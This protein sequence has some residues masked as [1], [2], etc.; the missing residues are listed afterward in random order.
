MLSVEPLKSA[1]GAANYYSNAFNYYSGDASAMKWLGQ[2]SER[3]QLIGVVEKEQMLSLLE[4]R[5]PDGRRLQNLEGE[6]RPGFD[7]TFS[8]PKSVSILV[9]LGVAPELIEFHDEAVEFTIRQI[10]KEFAETR[11]SRQGEISFEKTNNLIVAA[12]RQPSSRANEP[13]LHTHCV[14]MN[15]TFHEGDVRSLASDP[16]R[17]HGVIEQIQ[18]NAHYCG[19]IYRQYLANKIKTAGFHLRITGEGLFEIDGVPEKILQAY[20]TRR[21]EILEYMDEKK[22]SGAKSASIATKITRNI[23]EEHD[24]DV[25]TNAWKE[26]A[27]EMGFDAALFMQHRNKSESMSWCSSIKEKLLAWVGQCKKDATPSEKD[28]A[29]ACVQVAIE[30]LSQ[31][32]SIFSERKLTQEAMKHS[33]IYPSAVSRQSIVECIQL[34]KKHQTLYEE[35]CHQRNET[36]LTTPWLLTLEADTIARIEYNKGLVPAISTL[37][38]V[39]DFQKMRSAVLPYPMTNSQQQA[40]RVLLTSKDRYLAIQGYAGVAK[41]SMLSEARLLI[42]AQGYTLRGITVAS[43]AAHE[44]QDKAGIKADVFPI[45]HQELKEAKTASLPKT[46]FII[47]EASMLSS[48]QGHELIKQIERVGARLVLVGDKAQ[49]PS[50]NAGR[51]FGLIQEYGIET[52]VMDE[53]VRQKNEILKHAVMAT[54]RGDVKDALDHL[55]VQ[56]LSTHE[57]RIIWIANRWLSLSVSEREGTLLFA[58]THANREEITTLIRQGLKQEGSLQGQSF[59]HTVLKAKAMESIQ[60]RFVAYYQE[61]DQVR[62]NQTFKQGQLLAGKYYTVGKI[63]KKHCQDNTLPLIDEKG[64]ITKLHLNHLPHYKTHTAPF[65]RMIEVY[66]PK[67]LELL[68]GDKVMWTRNFRAYELRNGQCATLHEIKKDSLVFISNDGSKLILE[69]SHPALKHLDYSYVLT[70]YKVQGKDAPFG[71]GLMESYHRF[72][73]TLNNFYVQISRAIHG[74]TLVT[75][76]KEEL[77]RAILRNSNEKPASLDM[78]RSEQLMYHE[79]RFSG[80][81]QLSIQPVIDR[82]QFIER[83]VSTETIHPKNSTNNPFIKKM[84][85]D[86]SKSL[87]KEKEL[88]R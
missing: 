79:R 38:T 13:A 77:M 24:I 40:M 21:T 57:E 54:T 53:V 1:Q 8:A 76:N 72:G 5:L 74:M 60:L 10:E 80:K 64:H 48:H 56:L 35:R 14:T 18:N 67:S 27:T 41:T 2:G 4:G 44:L 63:S 75:D 26:R 46:L 65:E 29:Y 23:K 83:Q 9:G 7:M 86:L 17:I 39:K 82:K 36:F 32:T 15:M 87:R 68:V 85:V 69:K 16:S 3:L 11:V 88:E 52:T 70:N 37:E 34:E 62:F 73:T 61:G 33:L 50:V 66:K 49:L 45:V 22:W 19:L 12:F 6:H 25:L 71:I 43:S 58:P 30:T 84:D 28:A 20:S 55:D 47:D 78:T 31:R 51:M 42:E 59:S 81:N